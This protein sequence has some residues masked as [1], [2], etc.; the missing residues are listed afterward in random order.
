M[1]VEQ[2][3]GVGVAA[4]GP[5]RRARSAGCARPRTPPRRWPGRRR[6]TRRRPGR[7]ADASAPAAASVSSQPA[8]RRERAPAATPARRRRAAA[9]GD[10]ERARRRARR[11]SSP[12][13]RSCPSRGMLMTSL[14]VAALPESLTAIVGADHAVGNQVVR[15]D[16]WSVPTWTGPVGR[17]DQRQRSAPR[18]PRSATPAATAPVTAP[19]DGAPTSSPAR[20]A[21]RPVR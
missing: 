11:A 14:P 7:A 1:V 9:R 18:R 13:A 12:R 10:E 8:A 6:R 19:G 21:L 20:A 5:A 3:E 4:C 16:T 15:R 17:A 2:P